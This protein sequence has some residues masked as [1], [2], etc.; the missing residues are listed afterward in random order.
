MVLIVDV[1]WKVQLNLVIDFIYLLHLETYKKEEK[2]SF[3]F[4]T[5]ILI[6]KL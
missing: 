6:Y 1:A 2:F 4:K 3:D 5:E